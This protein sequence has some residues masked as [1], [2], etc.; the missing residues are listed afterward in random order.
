MS[1]LTGFDCNKCG[2]CCRNLDKSDIYISLHNGDGICRHLDQMTNLCT[3][4]DNRPALCN[5]DISYALYFSNMMSK[6]EFYLL[7][8]KGCE[9]LW[10]RKS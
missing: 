7:N 6:K 5:I 2:L 9:L 3:I 8:R 10:K 1:K 4:Y